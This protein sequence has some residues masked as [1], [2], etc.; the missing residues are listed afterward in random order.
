M[1]FWRDILVIEMENSGI[2]HPVAARFG[3]AHFPYPPRPLHIEIEADTGY[4]KRADGG[5]VQALPYFITLTIVF[6]KICCLAVDPA[7]GS[8]PRSIDKKAVVRY[9][10]NLL[11]ADAG[12]PY[13]ITFYCLML[14]GSGHFGEEMGMPTII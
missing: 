10:R 8:Q 4:I 1:A 6:Y 9:Q 11:S 13:S 14:A 7:Q 2:N 3:L 12:F 5:Q